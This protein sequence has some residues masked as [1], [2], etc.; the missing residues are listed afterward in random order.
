MVKRMTPTRDLCLASIG[1]LRK[2]QDLTDLPNNEPNK[3]ASANLNKSQLDNVNI[4]RGR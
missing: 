4:L 1:C 3:G 2:K